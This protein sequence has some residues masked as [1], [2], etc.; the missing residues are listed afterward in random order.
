MEHSVQGRTKTCGHPGQAN[1]MAHLQTIVL[2]KC[3]QHLFSEGGRKL[4]FY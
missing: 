1:N 4:I 3:V 2:Q